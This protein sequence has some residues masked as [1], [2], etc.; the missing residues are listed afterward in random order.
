MKR[1]LIINFMTL[2]ITSLILVMVIFSWYI[3]NQEV[4]ASGITASTGSNKL[5]VSSTYSEAYETAEFEEDS[6]LSTF[7]LL[8]DEYWSTNA[9]IHSNQLLL[10]SST[11]DGNTF[12]Y[13]ND[14]NEQGQA[15]TTYV[16]ANVD[17]ST[18][19]T[20]G[21]LYT[22]NNQTKQ[23]IA[24]TS[25]TYSSSTIYYKNTYNFLDI[26]NVGS[27]YYI[28][29]SI[30]ICNAEAT[31]LTCCIRKL[32]ISQGTDLTSNIFKSVRVYLETNNENE[33]FK[34]YDS[35]EPNAGNALPATSTSTIA[36]LDPA[37][38]SGSIP[39]DI[40]K[41]SLPGIETVD[42]TTTYTAVEIKVKIWVEGQNPNAIATYAGTGFNV[43][44]L[45]VTL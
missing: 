19:T 13:T 42:D 31:D 17:S 34:Y 24:V 35:T 16:R 14:I 26:T 3:S 30:Y 21:S 28:S 25:G 45:F 5:L 9:T 29:K 4:S 33:I 22:Y 7:T 44:L 8:D 32:T 37:S 39:D 40:L 11:N 43:D 18:F 38:N 27:Y 36:S 12:Y 6:Y 41:F 20:D 2:A 23:Y 15:I 10:P 1:N